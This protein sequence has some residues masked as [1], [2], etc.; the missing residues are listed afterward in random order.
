MKINPSNA[1]ELFVWTDVDTTYEDDFNE[2]YDR[3][4]MEERV[5]I[6]GFQWAQT[7]PIYICYRPTLPRFIPHRK[8]QNLLYS[9]LSKRLPTPN[10]LV[11]YQLRTH[12]QYQPT[13]D[14]C[15]AGS[16]LWQ[17]SVCCAGYV[18]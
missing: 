13:R 4:H 8:H 12:D 2:W 1:A 18:R 7:I 6:E 14:A 3:E 17:W 5:A 16:R 10:R 11:K 15:N 9:Q